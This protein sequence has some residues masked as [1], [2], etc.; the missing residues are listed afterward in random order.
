MGR[1]VRLY[2]GDYARETVFSEDPVSMAL[3]WQSLGATR[4]HIVDLD[5]ASVGEVRHWSLIGEIVTQTEIPVQVGGGVRNL[6]TVEAL[7]DMGV[8]RVVLGTVA[9][10]EPSLVTEACSK[11]GEGVVVSVDA[12]NG[13]AATRGWKN[14]TS[15]K[16]IDLMASLV[17]LGVQRFVYTDIASDGT[18]SQP[19]FTVIQ[20]VVS[21]T[22]AD[23]IAAG[24]ISSVDHVVRLEYIGVGG[25]IVGRALYEGRVNLREVREALRR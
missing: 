16:A 1:C 22:D 4:L 6:F 24:G 2:Q 20:E 3:H 12:R 9:V 15:V 5:G 7:L 21:Q 18:L 11:F 25:V 8:S 19:D 13:H 10:E 23:I 17:D 14:S